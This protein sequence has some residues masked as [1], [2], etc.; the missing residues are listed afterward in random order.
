M[1]SIQRALIQNNT[2]LIEVTI[3]SGSYER[4]VNGLLEYIS[5]EMRDVVKSVSFKQLPYNIREMNHMSLEGIDVM[6]LCHSIHNRGLALTDLD[7]SLYDKFLKK[8]REKLGGSSNSNSQSPISGRTYCYI[9]FCFPS[10]PYLNTSIGIGNQC[11]SCKITTP[12]LLA[13][14]CRDQGGITASSL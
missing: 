7:D 9:L 3:C 11:F 1:D 4:S 8:A 5:Q 13:K 6:V 12:F 2:S 14:S 10:P